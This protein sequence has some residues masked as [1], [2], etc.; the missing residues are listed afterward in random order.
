MKYKAICFDIDG[1]LYPIGTMNRRIFRL[2]VSH[3]LFGL[4]YRKARHEVRRHQA[5]F[6]QNIP[7]RWREAMVIQNGVYVGMDNAEEA[8]AEGEE[9]AEDEEAAEE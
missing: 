7:F 6:R 4:K 3:P 9:P 2:S 5:P 8:P 1:T